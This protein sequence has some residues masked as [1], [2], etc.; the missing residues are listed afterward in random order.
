[1]AAMVGPVGIQHADLGHGRIAALL[2][3]EIGPDM[4]KVLKSHGQPQRIVERPQF[5]LL[6]VPKARKD[7]HI[8]RLLKNRNQRVRLLQAGLPG[9]HG[10]DAVVFDSRKFFVRH[11]P[12]DHIGDGRADDRLFILF[13]KLDA[14]LRGIRPLVELPRKILYGKYPVFLL[15]RN[16][17]PVQQIHRRLRKDSSARFF[18]GFL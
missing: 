9:I 10:V 7:L 18:K 4:E 11:R 6:H 15:H 17:L 12:L 8:L 16:L 13:D 5:L 14:L 2:S 3:E 1:M